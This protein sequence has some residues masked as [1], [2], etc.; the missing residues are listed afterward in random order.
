M[1]WTHRAVQPNIGGSWL[2]AT[3]KTKAI[4]RAGTR[5]CL[6]K[7]GASSHVTLHGYRIN[8]FSL[9]GKCKPLF[10]LRQG[11]TTLPR[12]ALCPFGSSGSPW[13][14]SVPVPPSLTEIDWTNG[15]TVLLSMSLFLVT[16]RFIFS[17]AG[18]IYPVPFLLRF[19]MGRKQIGREKQTVWPAGPAGCR[20]AWERAVT[21]SAGLAP[22]PLHSKLLGMDLPAS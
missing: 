5:L 3:Q 1:P 9:V 22:C 14:P 19:F 7:R 16:S 17:E 8:Y 21:S 4:S 13:I 2:W 20:L 18:T 12:L 6:C 11:L 10:V 15:C